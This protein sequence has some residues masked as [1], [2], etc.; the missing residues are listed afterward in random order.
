MSQQS[1][2]LCVV[3]AVAGASCG[4]SSPSANQP[5][6]PSPIAP[7]VLTR[8]TLSGSNALTAIGDTTQLVGIASWSNGTTRDVTA[9][10][11]W[12]S[13]DPSVVT[14]SLSGL[15]TAVGFGVA[16]IDAKYNGT[17]NGGI[18][19]VTISVTPAGTFAVAG[20]V[21]EPGQGTLAGVRVLEPV[22]GKSTLTNQSGAYT[23]S[24][25]AGT[26]LRFVKDGYEPGELDIA[27]DNTAYMRMQ[28]IVRMAA[29]ETATVPK[30]THMDVYYDIGPD[31]CSPCRLIRIVVPAAGTMRFELAW[32]PNPGADLYLWVGGQRLDGERQDRQFTASAAVRAGE[33]LV[34]V[35]YYRWKVLYGSSI[36]FTLATSMS[37]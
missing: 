26:R 17:S 4:G 27:P 33:N 31:R 16:S 34:Y 15:A 13:A 36:K 3:L 2:A 25:L 5:A 35:G 10:I 7:N 12:T 19:R 8:L 24:G 37:N 29:G 32:E 14:V 21:R 28:R 30:L 9:E 20:D 11:T 22:S 1:I 23:L 6:G 18:W